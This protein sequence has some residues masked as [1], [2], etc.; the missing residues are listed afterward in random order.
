MYRLY[1]WQLHGLGAGFG[2]EPPHS[3]DYSGT[4][5]EQDVD[6]YYPGGVAQIDTSF[7]VSSRTAE[8]Y[9]IMPSSAGALELARAGIISLTSE[10]DIEEWRAK[11]QLLYSPEVARQA[12]SGT[13]YRVLRSVTIPTGL[14]GA[15]LTP[16]SGFCGLE[17]LDL[18][19]A[20]ARHQ[21]T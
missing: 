20:E 18:L 14:C 19:P 17:A 13:F 11:A 7:L 10:S 16:G 21:P 2:I 12:S 8:S 15:E 9:T 1:K 4:P 6:T 3:I 5:L